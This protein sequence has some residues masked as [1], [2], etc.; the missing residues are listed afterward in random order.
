[1]GEISTRGEPENRASGTP[2]VRL[3][4]R[5]EGVGGPSSRPIGLTFDYLG[6]SLTADPR[7]W[8]STTPG[9]PTTTEA[10]IE[11]CSCRG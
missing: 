7:Q 4:A 3:T 5:G 6:G 8:A 2:R 10:I 1:M 9:P 11:G